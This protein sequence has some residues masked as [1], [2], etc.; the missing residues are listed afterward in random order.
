MP[1]EIAPC[2]HNLSSTHWEITQA[3]HGYVKQMS[4][5][6]LRIQKG[7]DPKL[8]LFAE[9]DYAEDKE[10]EQLILGEASMHVGAVTAW[11]YISRRYS[12]LSSTEI[13][14]VAIERVSIKSSLFI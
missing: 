4:H 6:G 12:P 1:S 3:I 5:S 13:E 7:E 9:S 2:E 11:H 8:T 10:H 14:H